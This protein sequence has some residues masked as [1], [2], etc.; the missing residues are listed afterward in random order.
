MIVDATTPADVRNAVLVAREQG[1]PVSVYATGHG[2][3]MPEGEDVAVITTAGMT[4]VLVDPQRRVARVGAGVRWAEVIAAAAPFGLAPLSGT[5]P[6]VGVVGYT[7]GGGMGWLSRRFGFAADSVL[8]A[9]IVTA[10]GEFRTVSADREP[11][12]FWAIR[13][14]GA[15]FGVVT[16]LE[17]RLHP[18]ASVYAGTATFDAARTADVLVAYRDAELPD[19]LTANIVLTPGGLA[20]RGMYAGAAEDA[21]R[22]L[23]PLFR[24]AGEPVTDGWRTMSYTESGTVGGVAPRNFSL[25]RDLPV[26]AVL[27]AMDG[28]ATTVEVRR[29][30]GVIARPAACAGPVGHRDVPFSVV[31]DGPDDAAAPVLAHATGGSFLNWLPDPA[32]THTAYTAADWARLREI[33]AAY[34]PERVFTPVKSIPPAVRPAVALGA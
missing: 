23:A 28:G 26:D 16:A 11:D 3:P 29:W 17:F 13:G 15:N 18:V 20:I 7:L 9:D 25:Q 2:G 33:K 8:R 19:E 1:L 5:S 4:G 12:L 34:D 30:G 24:A 6:T 32:R 27:A 14:G 31:V 22:A 21:R 10:D